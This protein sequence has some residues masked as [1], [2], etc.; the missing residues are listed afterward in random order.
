MNKSEIY[1]VK[2]CKIE[3]T[4]IGIS[5]DSSLILKINLPSRKR[6]TD[7]QLNTGLLNCKTIKAE[8]SQDI[9]TYIE[10]NDDGQVNLV[11]LWDALR[12]YQEERCYQ[13]Q[14]H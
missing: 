10:E 12:Q 1:N 8:I 3:E 14:W 7:W 9:K 5:D 2:E 11:I 4:S 6:K 13:K